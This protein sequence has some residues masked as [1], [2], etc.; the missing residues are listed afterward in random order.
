MDRR[1]ALKALGVLAG[2]AALEGCAVKHVASA[3]APSPPASAPQL[4]HLPK[5]DV[6]PDREIRTVVGLR[7]FR[8][9]GF[10][11][12][13]QKVDDKLVVHNYGH[14]GGGVTLSWGTGELACREVDA[15]ARKI[16]PCWDAAPSVWRPLDCCRSAAA[17]SRS[18]PKIFPLTRRQTSQERSG[19]RSSSFS[20]VIG[21]PEFMPRFVEA[22]HMANRR[23]QMMV[24]ARYGIRWLPNYRMGQDPIPKEACSASTARFA[25]DS[26]DARSCSRR[27]IP[28]L[29]R[30]CA[31][32]TP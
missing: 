13:A 31:S 15:P 5:V 25:T 14:G 32:S 1:S 9:S 7:P 19:F 20:G 3:T 24:G 12:S 11:V 23:Y 10:V 26:G 21:A 29:S 22:S 4:I 18:M 27:K 30:K 16:L 8:P 6:Q 28:F 17:P 2:A